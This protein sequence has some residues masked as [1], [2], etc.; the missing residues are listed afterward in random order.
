MNEDQR[1]HL[2]FIQ[3]AITRLSTNSMQLKAISIT[4]TAGLLAVYSS[5]PKL[6]LI[7]LSAI[8][9]IFFWAL[10]AYYLQQERKF[11]GI[12]DD[13]VSTTAASNIS[14]YHMPTNLYKTGRYHF[15]NCMFSKSK[16]LFFLSVIG[17]LTLTIAGIQ[18]GWFDCLFKVSK[19]R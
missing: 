8:Q 12:Y 13:L 15:F 17:I 4:L 10:D 18:Y 19:T 7:Y 5:T 3:A 11:R 1:K 2:E 16:L 14:V 9:M 6:F